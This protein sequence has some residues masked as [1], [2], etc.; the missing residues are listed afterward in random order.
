MGEW[1]V[2]SVKKSREGNRGQGTGKTK[3]KEV[4]SSGENRDME[5]EDTEDGNTTKM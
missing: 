2:G 1:M 4:R 5:E 3:M